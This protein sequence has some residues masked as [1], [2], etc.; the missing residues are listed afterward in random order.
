L[1]IH[2]FNEREPGP[3]SLYSSF[4]RMVTD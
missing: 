3:G 1:G 4:L 2:R